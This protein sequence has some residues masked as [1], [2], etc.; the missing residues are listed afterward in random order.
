MTGHTH[1]TGETLEQ[2]PERVIFEDPATHRLRNDWDET[3]AAV[4]I[5]GTGVRHPRLTGARHR[6]DVD[7]LR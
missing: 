5:P 6:W 2:L 3:A 4:A 7:V 1:T